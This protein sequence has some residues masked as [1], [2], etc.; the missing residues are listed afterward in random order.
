VG[1]ILIQMYIDPGA[2]SLAFQLLASVVV[3]AVFTFRRGLSRVI[4]VFRK[5]GPPGDSDSP[6]DGGPIDK[7]AQ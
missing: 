6:D 4:R 7:S 2:G 5:G 3:G 1:Y